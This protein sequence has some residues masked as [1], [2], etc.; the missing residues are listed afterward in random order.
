MV[1]LYVQFPED[2]SSPEIKAKENEKATVAEILKAAK[3]IFHPY[4]M[5]YKY[6]DWWTIYRIGQRVC[7]KASYLDRV[8]LAGDAIHSKFMKWR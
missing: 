4:T 2:F 7:N 3:S 1:R 5:D 6:C 8:F